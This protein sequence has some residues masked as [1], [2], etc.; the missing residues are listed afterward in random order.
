M[1]ALLD[2]QIDARPAVGADHRAAGPVAFVPAAPE[3]DETPPYLDA[4][5]NGVRM[6]PAAFDAITE[7]DARYEYELVNGVLV[8]SP[9]PADGHEAQVDMLAHLLLSYKLN[10]PEGAAL[11]LTL[12]GRYVATSWGRRKADRV[13]WCGLGRAPDSNVDVPSVVIEV[14]SP[15]RR[16]RVRDYELKRDEYREAG[17]LEYWLVDPREPSLTTFTAAGGWAEATSGA[18]GAL[19]TPL[20]PGFELPVNALLA[21]ADAVGDGGDA[22][23]PADA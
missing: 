4:S 15:R 5:F 20:L 3:P 2:A 7:Y 12:P 23:R 19:T 21:V 10:H 1:P 6:T 9:A 11:D 8:V 18:G 16:D 22:D 17:V 13:L 14:V